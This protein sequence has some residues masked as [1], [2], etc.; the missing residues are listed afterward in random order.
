MA[1]EDYVFD[2]GAN[3]TPSFG[4]F[5]SLIEQAIERATPNPYR[6][7]VIRSSTPPAVVGQPTGYPTNWNSFQ[8]RCIW[9]N[10]DGNAYR[11]NGTTWV[12]IN[13]KPASLS[14]TNDLVVDAT[15]RLGKLSAYGA[16][17]NQLIRA[18]AGGTFEYVDA[19][20]TI[21]QNTLPIDRLVG[22]ATSVTSLLRSVNGIKSWLTL[23]SA[24]II[25]T[26][27]DASI[28]L[29]KLIPGAN[30]QIPMSVTTGGTTVV[31]WGTVLS[32]IADNA[33]PWTKLAKDVSAAGKNLEVDSNGQ[34]VAV[35][36]P[37]ASFT[38]SVKEIAAI[39]GIGATASV[40][41][42]LTTVP[43]DYT[44]QFVCTVAD[45]GFAVGDVIKI[46]DVTLDVWGNVYLASMD[47]TNVYIHRR[48][49]PASIDIINKTTR[50]MDTFKPDR[51]KFR[52]SCIKYA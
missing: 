27:A 51:W 39:P 25:S 22:P 10:D 26:I 19:I 12:L 32:G 14:V 46:S 1:N 50:L 9:I 40:A 16:T 34:I 41:H 5:A 48:N 42:G 6:G 24:L 33:I 23:D 49:D 20:N 31:Q 21:S 38:R 17:A 3:L 4:S 45:A 11:H 8:A 28:A 2:R 13:A 15:I 36:K 29:G 30:L 52:V 44:P 18:T 7:M 37:G 35:D 47:A 43:D